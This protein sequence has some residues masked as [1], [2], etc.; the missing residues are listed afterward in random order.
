MQLAWFIFIPIQTFLIR[1][2]QTV[3]YFNGKIFVKIQTHSRRSQRMRKQDFYIHILQAM[4]TSLVIT[5]AFAALMELYLHKV[6]KEVRAGFLFL[7]I[8]LRNLI[9]TKVLM[10][11]LKAERHNLFQ[12]MKNSKVRFRLLF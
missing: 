7:N 9:C 6:E 3:V 2:L 4:Q 1:W 8:S 5:L 12:A 10:R 11:K